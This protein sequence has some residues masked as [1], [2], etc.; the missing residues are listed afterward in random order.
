MRQQE[1]AVQGPRHKWDN[2]LKVSHMEC[3]DVNKVGQEQGFVNTW[4]SFWRY[5]SLVAARKWEIWSNVSVF[6]TR[7][8]ATLAQCPWKP[9]K[10]ISQLY[11]ISISRHPRYTAT[12][13]GKKAAELYRS[14]TL[15]NGNAMIYSLLSSEKSAKDSNISHYNIKQESS[16]QADKR[17][18]VSKQTVRMI[19]LP[20]NS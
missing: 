12:N 9:V 1:Q 10:R 14:L 5:I 13:C 7:H 20:L 15:C 6:N 17:F 11:R 16:L 3:K 4:K 2:H 18:N 8:S 19:V